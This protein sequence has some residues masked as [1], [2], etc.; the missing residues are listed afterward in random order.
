MNDAFFNLA[1]L[2]SAQ[3]YPLWQRLWNVY[4]DCFAL[5]RSYAD[6]MDEITSASMQRL[7]GVNKVAL[8]DLAK[9]GIAKRGERE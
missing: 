5:P 8:N 3:Q 6:R 7:L 2:D 9:R 4:L 1:I